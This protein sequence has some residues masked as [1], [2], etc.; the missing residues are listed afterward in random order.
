VRQVEP[1]TER[2]VQ[3]RLIGTNLEAAR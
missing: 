3:Q 1:G 2:R